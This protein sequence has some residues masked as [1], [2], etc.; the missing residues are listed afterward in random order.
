M[1]EITEEQLDSLEE[2]YSEDDK[3]HSVGVGCR[4]DV[5][6]LSRELRRVRRELADALRLIDELRGPTTTSRGP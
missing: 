4:N 6:A 1:S 3:L 5:L 2:F